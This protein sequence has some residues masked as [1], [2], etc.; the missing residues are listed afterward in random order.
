MNTNIMT[1]LI[2]VLALQLTTK[3]DQ[4]LKNILTDWRRISQ[5][6]DVNPGIPGPVETEFL[7][8]QKL[9]LERFESLGDGRD[10][11]LADFFDNREN[12]IGLR[13]AALSVFRKTYKDTNYTHP[14]MRSI[15]RDLQLVVDS[16]FEYKGN[17]FSNC[18]FIL[19]R[20][21]DKRD[22]PL[23]E[24][25]SLSPDP[26]YSWFC[27]G[28]INQIKERISSEREAKR[29]SNSDTEKYSNKDGKAGSTRS[30]DDRQNQSHR[31]LLLIG[32]FLFLIAAL[33]GLVR[34]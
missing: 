29:P 4:E 3:A 30:G 19:S 16:D 8:N 18:V 27:S 9:I 13:E 12:D 34:K 17:L 1:F 14:M 22:L 23:L 32:A 26:G 7:K 33:F 24:A 2:L 5:G 31:T 20:L 21:G 15:R 10:Q 11:A 28:A 25:L 6:H